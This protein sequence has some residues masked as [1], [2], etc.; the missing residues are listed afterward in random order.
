[1]SPRHVTFCPFRVPVSV[2]RL[3]LLGS[4]DSGMEAQ[5]LGASIVVR[6][7]GSPKSTREGVGDHM[8]FPRGYGV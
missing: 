5:L 1:M 8:S 3:F 7:G 2:T 6:R 4:A